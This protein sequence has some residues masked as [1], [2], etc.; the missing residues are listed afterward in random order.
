MFGSAATRQVNAMSDLTTRQCTVCTVDTVPLR[1]AELSKLHGQLADGWRLV[2]EH[3]LE[4]VYRFRDF[5]E[6][7]AFANRVGDL[8]EAEGH[9]P[10][11][12]VSWGKVRLSVWTHKS[13]G[14]TE[15]DFILA[16]KVDQ[17]MC[18]TS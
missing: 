4:R 17:L 5:R 9:H 15:N 18:P 1:G 14:L 8:A 7:M 11:I 6:A 16:A 2:E 3:H 10:E 13:N 12:G